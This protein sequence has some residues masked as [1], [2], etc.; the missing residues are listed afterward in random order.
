MKRLLG[1]VLAVSF[2]MPLTL[3]GGCNTIDGAGK[4]I[5]QGGAKIQSEAREHRN[6]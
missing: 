2:A 4:D 1:L 3:L 6:Y 5:Q